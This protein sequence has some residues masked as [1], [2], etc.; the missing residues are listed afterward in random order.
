MTNEHIA[1]QS[2]GIVL[3]CQGNH[4]PPQLR[5]VNPLPIVFDNRCRC[6]VAA[7]FSERLTSVFFDTGGYDLSKIPF[8]EMVFILVFTEVL[9]PVRCANTCYRG[10]NSRSIK[11]VGLFHDSDKVTEL[12]ALI[13]IILPDDRL[14]MVPSLAEGD[15]RETLK[16]IRGLAVKSV[17]DRKKIIRQYQTS[18]TFMDRTVLSREKRWGEG[19]LYATSVAA[20]KIVAAP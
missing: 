6:S 11:F 16:W 2:K 3:S 17:H 12:V 1:A 15:V 20:I 7:P 5:L 13:D 14:E 10:V 19:G 9:G 8:F 18:I 4:V